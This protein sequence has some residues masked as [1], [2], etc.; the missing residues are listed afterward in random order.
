MGNATALIACCRKEKDDPKAGVIKTCNKQ[1]ERPTNIAKK[2]RDES[3]GP[4]SDLSIKV[5]APPCDV[6][7]CLNGEESLAHVQGVTVITSL[8]NE[9]GYFSS[10]DQEYYKRLYA[11]EEKIV[12][13]FAEKIE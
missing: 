3:R 13:R 12:A 6:I 8:K 9:D 11:N 10:E 5:L 1:E 7:T 2:T 4:N